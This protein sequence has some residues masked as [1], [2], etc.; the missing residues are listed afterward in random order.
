MEYRKFHNCLR[1]QITADEQS[2]ER[3]EQLVTHCLKYGF[4]NVILMINVE[5]FNVGHITTE[6]A[7]EWVKVLKRAKEALK[8]NGIT[9]SVN[10]WMDFGHAD[11]GRTF[12][13]DQKF[14]TMTDMNGTESKSVVCPLGENWQR[15]FSEYTKYL[16]RELKPD[17]FW[18]EDD[19]RL[20]N[21][22]PLRGTGCFCEA[23]MKYYNEIL[24]TNYTREEFVKKV[25]ARGKCNA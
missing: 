9:V 24:H 8:T 22:V 3:I 20:H 2:K 13:P 14:L 1:L 18:I 4:D 23:H 12:Q 15:Y 10:N 17:T 6:Q 19:F 7:K 25:F 16:V 5:E 21:H 11:R